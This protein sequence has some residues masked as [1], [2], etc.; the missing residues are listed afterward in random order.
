MLASLL[1]KKD[2]EIEILREDSLEKERELLHALDLL[3]NA[4]AR[5]GELR[6]Q[7][8]NLA[9]QVDI[10]RDAVLEK[11]GGDSLIDDDL[12]GM[13]SSPSAVQEHARI[14]AR[15]EEALA[16]LA[17]AREDVQVAEGSVSML[18]SALGA[19]EETVEGLQKQIVCLQT[20]IHSVMGNRDAAEPIMVS[21]DAIQQSVQ[22]S[23]A[24]VASGLVGVV[25]AVQCA[26]RGL[27]IVSDI[28]NR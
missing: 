17:V 14:A 28:F 16:Q 12:E 21:A 20:Y 7:A 15:L 6:R 27:A 13:C 10:M 23:G 1:Q 8:C 18:K 9:A 24:K 2:R 26:A 22:R 5:E 3:Q 4:H 19:A 25:V 11:E